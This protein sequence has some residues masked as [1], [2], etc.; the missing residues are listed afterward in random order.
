MMRAG[1]D[2]TLSAIYLLVALGALAA[3]AAVLLRGQFGA[4]GLDGIFLLLVCLLF[5]AVFGLIGAQTIRQTFLEEWLARRKG[6]SGPAVPAAAAAAG[7]A[8]AQ[9]DPKTASKV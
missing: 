8:A 6:G 3:A 5:A 9:P 4:T 2:L 1:E 7:A